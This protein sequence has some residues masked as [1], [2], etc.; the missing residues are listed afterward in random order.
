MEI[1]DLKT[2]DIVQYVYH[3]CDDVPAIAHVLGT[4]TLSVHFQDLWSE[5][6]DL[7]NW[8]S[9]NGDHITILAVLT[10]I[11]SVNIKEIMQVYTPELLI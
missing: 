5:D 10:N 3:G 4:D 9:G 1:S 8:Q 6:D 2:G 11:P 7:S